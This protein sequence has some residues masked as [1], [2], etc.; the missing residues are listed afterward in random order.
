MLNE[1][2]LPPSEA[3]IA[4]C[5]AND[6]CTFLLPA[7]WRRARAAALRVAV[8]LRAT[9][10]LP[11]RP[12]VFVRLFRPRFAAIP[13]LRNLG[14]LL[15]FFS[16]LYLSAYSPAVSLPQI[17]YTFSSFLLQH[18][19]CGPWL[20]PHM[21]LLLCTVF[22]V[23]LPAVHHRHV[24]AGRVLVHYYHRFLFGAVVVVLDISATDRFFTSTVYAFWVWIGADSRLPLRLLPGLR[25]DAC[26]RTHLLCLSACLPR[27]G[28]QPRAACLPLPYRR[29]ISTFPFCI[30]LPSFR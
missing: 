26:V 23:P 10:Q 6:A 25:A 28:A 21:C 22:A 14:S 27:P 1:H 3:R 20:Y 4:L 11:P 19:Y 13:L 8:A 16:V 9:C 17:A 12:A 29:S 18:F 30:T 15:A 7:R 24:R 5:C 2:H